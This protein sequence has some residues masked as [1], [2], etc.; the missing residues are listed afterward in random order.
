MK[1]R[2]KREA[3]RNAS[4]LVTRNNLK[5]STESAKYQGQLFRSFRAS[6][7]LRSYQGRRASRC[8][9]LA[10]G[11]HISRL[12]RW[13]ALTYSAPSALAL[14]TFCANFKSLRATQID[15]KSQ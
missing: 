10:P 1:A 15:I 12:R 3:Q 9:A 4:P 14:A 6:S 2:G 5:E 13:R 11:F 7:P 8:S